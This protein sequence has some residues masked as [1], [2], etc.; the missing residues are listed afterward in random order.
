MDGL[1][2]AVDAQSIRL[3]TPTEVR[4]T[5]GSGDIR[6][7]AEEFEAIFVKELLK[8]MRKSL[9]PD[10]DLLHGGMSQEIFEDMLYDE[11]AHLI[12]EA[13]DFG[14]ADAVVDQLGS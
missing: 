7:V 10:N 8:T 2:S 3:M 12:A 11:Y 9:N 14:V 6:E 1:S 4:P 5:R 13:G